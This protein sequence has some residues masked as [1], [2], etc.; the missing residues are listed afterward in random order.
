MHLIRNS[1]DHGI[2][3]KEDRIER[4]KPEKG[5]VQLE[6]RNE[7]GDVWIIVKDDG[8]GLDRQKILKKAKEKDLLTK[9]AEEYSDKEIYQF[10]LLPGFSTKE[11]V[12]EISGRGV[13]M[14][15]VKT[16]IEKIGGSILID[17][18]M[19][20][21]STITIKIPLTLAIIDGMLVS[22]GRGRY[23][24]PTASIRESFKLTQ[25]QIVRDTDGTEMIMI[26]GSCHALIR[27]HDRFGVRPKVT[28]LLDGIIIA[29]EN[30]TETVCL[31][32]DELIGEQQVVVKPM[33]GYIRKSKGIA[34]C[35]IQ[36]DGT[37]SLIID[38]KGLMDD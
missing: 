2:E 5:L 10:V 17:S 38:I 11:S 19:G 29:V 1:V 31:F 6:A 28:D 8:K 34:G 13:G 21:G 30:E 14:D 24:I 26:R 22:V 16:N 12:S 27:I 9:P 3:N 15:V 7:G 36:G 35:T 4:N 33:P 25:N 32:V 37:I 20:K 18:V 23:I